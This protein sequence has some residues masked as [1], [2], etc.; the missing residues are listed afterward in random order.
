MLLHKRQI[1]LPKIFLLQRLFLLQ[2]IQHSTQ[3]EFQMDHIPSLVLYGLMRFLHHL[4][5]HRDN[6]ENLIYLV[7]PKPMMVLQIIK[8][9]FFFFCLSKNGCSTNLFCI[10]TIYITDYLPAISFK[11]FSR[12]IAEP[13]I[14]MTINRNIVVIVECD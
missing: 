4:M 14:N 6:H 1:F 5:V 8:R 9:W 13:T 10:V 7:E 2:T 3:P 11:T 12:I